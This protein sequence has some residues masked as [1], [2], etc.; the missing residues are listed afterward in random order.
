MSGTS[1]VDFRLFSSAS[2]DLGNMGVRASMS[3][4]SRAS[5][6]RDAVNIHFLS[7]N[8]R[9]WPVMGFGYLSLLWSPWH[10]GAIPH[11][12]DAVCHQ[13][14]GIKEHRKTE[15]RPTIAHPQACE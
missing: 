11:T 15:L 4:V 14:V 1:V 8:H 5:A 13:S 9:L 10:A 3:V 2:L 6:S 12:S 7:V